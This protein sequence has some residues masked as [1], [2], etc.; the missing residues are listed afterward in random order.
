MFGVRSWDRFAEGLQAPQAAPVVADCEEC[1]G[2]IYRYEEVYDTH[3]G[4]F[5]KECLAD[6]CRSHG[7]Q[8]DDLEPVA[9]QADYE[10]PPW[11]D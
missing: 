6:Y 4:M 3:V 8:E 5:H 7:L 1:G 10:A 9:I 11:A 2:E